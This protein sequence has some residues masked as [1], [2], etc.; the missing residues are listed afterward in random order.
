MPAASYLKAYGN[1]KNNSTL[2]QLAEQKHLSGLYTLKGLAPT[3]RPD[4]ILGQLIVP[5]YILN[6][7]AEIVFLRVR[8]ISISLIAHHLQGI[9]QFAYVTKDAAVMAPEYILIGHIGQ[10]SLGMLF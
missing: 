6:P 8:M 7:V 10:P 2:L 4:Q 1:V 5:D 9:L 3:G